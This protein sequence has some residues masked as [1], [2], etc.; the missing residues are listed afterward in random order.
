[1]KNK[2]GIKLFVIL[3]ALLCLAACIMLLLPNEKE[4]INILLNERQTVELF[5]RAQKTLLN[6]Q[7]LEGNKFTDETMVSFALDYMVASGSYRISY[8]ELEGV[9]IVSKEDI[10][11]VVKYIFDKVISFENA[12]YRFDNKYVYIKVS[13]YS[14]DARIYK[15]KDE[16]VNSDGTYTIYIDCL[17]ANGQMYSELSKNS[18]TK[19]DEANVMMT[20]VFRYKI[21]NGR[22]VLLAY[23]CN[24]KWW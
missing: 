6:N 24:T 22:K 23:E 2:R 10:A 21:V 14:T 11:S 18:V 9:A 16:I 1:M 19:Y 17:E 12:K 15:F 4:N 8:D 7:G 5:K 3:I 13:Q 20:L